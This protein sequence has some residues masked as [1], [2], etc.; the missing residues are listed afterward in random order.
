MDQEYKIIGYTLYHFIQFVAD[1]VYHNSC[2]LGGSRTFHGMGIIATVTPGIKMSKSVHRVCVT[3]RE[4]A[5]LGHITVHPW[6][7]KR[8]ITQLRYVHIHQG[9]VF[10]IQTTSFI[11]VVEDI[12]II[13]S[14]CTHKVGNDADC[15]FRRFASWR[16][17]HR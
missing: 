10:I 6:L 7:S 15:V 8:D 4:L 5:K 13:Y 14:N 17:R 2:T 1:S 12:C 9:I 16:G 3:S 11:Y